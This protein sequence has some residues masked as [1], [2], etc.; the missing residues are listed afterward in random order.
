MIA[1]TGSTLLCMWMALATNGSLFGGGGG[2]RLRSVPSE[3]N[4]TEPRGP[5]KH[6]PRSRSRNAH[7]AI[8]DKIVSG[9]TRR[10]KQEERD[11]GETLD[12]GIYG[13]DRVMESRPH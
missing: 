12:D 2:G 13:G 6:V 1:G 8:L 11:R 4:S 9:E 3:P 7:R 5:T 10:Q